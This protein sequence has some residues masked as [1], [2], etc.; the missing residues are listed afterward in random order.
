MKFI[1]YISKF[2]NLILFSIK[3]NQSCLMGISILA[4][5]PPHLI[6]WFGLSYQIHNPT[7][8]NAVVFSLFKVVSWI[9]DYWLKKS[10]T[11]LSFEL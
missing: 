10:R 4:E 8:Y 2:S 9:V 5:T 1:H 7:Y 6:R 11:S 3:D